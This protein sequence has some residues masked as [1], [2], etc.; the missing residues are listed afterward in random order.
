MEKLFFFFFSFFFRKQWVGLRDG[1]KRSKLFSWDILTVINTFMQQ[2]RIRQSALQ[3]R[4]F[5][6][7]TSEDNVQKCFNATDAD[8]PKHLTGSNSLRS[9]SQTLSD[10]CLDTQTV[11]QTNVCSVIKSWDSKWDSLLT[12]RSFFFYQFFGF[13]KLFLQHICKI[14]TA[15]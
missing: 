4:N 2:M 13:I 12:A 5:M 9:V 14:Q 11:L 10:W 6:W 7:V 8:L 1:E 15:V 3:K